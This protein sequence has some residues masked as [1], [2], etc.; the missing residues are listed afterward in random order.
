MKEKLFRFSRFLFRHQAN[1]EGGKKGEAWIVCKHKI[2]PEPCGDFSH[3]FIK[4]L[5][6]FMDFPACASMGRR[7]KIKIRQSEA[8]NLRWIH[9]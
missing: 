6:H 8:H 3:A 7:K 5:T 1:A 9:D 4:H 2:Y